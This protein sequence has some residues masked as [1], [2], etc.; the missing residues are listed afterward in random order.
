MFYIRA[1]DWVPIGYCRHSEAGC[2]EECVFT[3]R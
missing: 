2:S 3:R 1:V